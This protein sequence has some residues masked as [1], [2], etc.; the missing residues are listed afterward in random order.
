MNDIVKE[1]QKFARAERVI[2]LAASGVE[3]RPA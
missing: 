3:K 1:F 2:A